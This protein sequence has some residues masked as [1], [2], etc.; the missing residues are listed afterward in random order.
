[1]PV[2]K[3]GRPRMTELQAE[4][5]E[6]LWEIGRRFWRISREQAVESPW[7]IREMGESVYRAYQTHG[8]GDEGIQ[9]L[10]QRVTEI[11]KALEQLVRE[12]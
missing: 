10:C 4:L 2:E 8:I 11:E 9:K 7:A 5:N 6:L 3:P 12:E 1:M